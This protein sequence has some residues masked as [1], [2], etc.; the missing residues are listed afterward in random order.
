MATVPLSGTNIRLLSGVPFSNDYKHTRW[1]SDSTAQTNYFLAKPAVHT[2][3]QANYQR[4]EGKHFIA[5]NKSIDELWGANYLMFQNSHYNQKWFYGFITKLEYVQK[6]TTY[7]HFQIDVLQ[8]WRFNYTFKPSYVVREHCK[9]WN[10]DGTPVVNTQDEG[11]NY[12]TAY[13]TVH[14]TNHSPYLGHRFL[15]I[16]SKTPLESTLNEVEARVI[17]VPQPLSYY[18][19]PFDSQFR[20]V[21]FSITAGGNTTTK[22]V[23]SPQDVLNETYKNEKAVNNIVSLYITESTGLRLSL[24]LN[25]NDPATISGSNLNGQSLAFV[26]ISGSDLQLVKVRTRLQFNAKTDTVHADKYT[27]FRPSKESKLLMYPYCLTILD[28]FKGNRVEVR[29]EHINKKELRIYTKGSLGTSNTTSYAVEGYNQGN[30]THNS[31]VASEHA[32]INSR[33]SDVPIVNDMLAAFLQGNKN[34]LQNQHNNILFNGVMDTIGSVIGGVASATT[35]NPLGVSPAI[36]VANAGVSVAKGAGNVVLQMQG[37]QAKQQDIGNIPP[38]IAK[39]GS[40]IAFD[41]GN[42]YEGVF[43]LKKQIKPEYQKVL[44][45]FFN[46]YGYKVNEVKIPNFKTRKYWNYV[47]TAD[48]NI[49][50]SLNNEDVQELKDIFNSGI[51]LWH[52]DDI[53]NYLLDNEVI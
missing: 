48:C 38:Q 49:I 47:Q 23:A 5:V 4:I 40:N 19:V 28:D 46:L 51:T 6:N 43:I 25:G 8:T 33:P 7:V 14:V 1:F 29:N 36:G 27:G 30:I 15:V 13:D 11:L 42:G 20:A 3:Q 24:T 32:L 17:G 18:I 31:Q 12:G 21:N 34:S 35:G 41:V 53:G 16:V 52:T 2:I 45:D 37:M 44:E 22:A 10:D 9:L 50:A 26:T 39:M